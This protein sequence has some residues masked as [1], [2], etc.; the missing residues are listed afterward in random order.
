MKNLLLLLAFTTMIVTLSC[1]K[2]Q[3]QYP[4]D[5]EQTKLTPT[6]RLVGKWWTLSKATLNGKD[7]TDSV[8]NKIGNFKFNL[9]T[10]GQYSLGKLDGY[11]GSAESEKE[12]GYGTYWNLYNNEECIGMSR[13]LSAF[14]YPTILIFPFY[15]KY[16]ETGFLLQRNNILKLNEH[17]LKISVQNISGDSIIINEFIN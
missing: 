7:Y 17:E 1:K 11:K 14:N 5:T 6:E 15:F 8:K 2:W 4:E 16:Y 10:A 3:H 9:E 13:I 12:G